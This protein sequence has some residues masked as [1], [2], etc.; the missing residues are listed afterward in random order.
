MTGLYNRGGERKKVRL[1]KREGKTNGY[2]KRTMLP[3]IVAGASNFTCLKQPFP[4]RLKSRLRGKREGW[5]LWGGVPVASVVGADEQGG[6]QV[7]AEGRVQR[8]GERAAEGVQQYH[9]VRHAVE[10]Q[11]PLLPLYEDADAGAGRGGH[12]GL[13]VVV[14]GGVAGVRAPQPPRV[15]VAPQQ[16]GLP[17]AFAS[18][19]PVGDADVHPAAALPLHLPVAGAAEL[20]LLAQHLG[21]RVEA[22]WVG[23]VGLGLLTAVGPLRA[24]Q[25]DQS[26]V[27][28]VRVQGQ[29]RWNWSREKKR[30]NSLRGRPLYGFM[31]I[32]RKLS[33]DNQCKNQIWICCIMAHACKWCGRTRQRMT[34]WLICWLFSWLIEICSYNRF[35]SLQKLKKLRLQLLNLVGNF[36]G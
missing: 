28:R 1:R 22:L 21:H 33:G 15:L 20:A 19:A 31:S 32:N 3:D 5:A 13:A 6:V 8:L 14:P 30:W 29:T 23:G 24:L 26:R 35:S 18:D 2:E 17:A 25:Q 11:R 34:C 16:A 4:A 10:G 9:R 7:Q 36:G 27:G 12:R